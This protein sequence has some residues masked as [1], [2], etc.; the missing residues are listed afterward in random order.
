MNKITSRKLTPEERVR[1]GRLQ[2]NV[3]NALRNT[4]DLSGEIYNLRKEA[5]SLKLQTFDAQNKSE[6]AYIDIS[7]VLIIV[8]IPAIIAIPKIGTMTIYSYF[9]IGLCA[10]VI[11]C[12]YL[13]IRHSLARKQEITRLREDDVDNFISDYQKSVLAQHESVKKQVEVI[14]KELGRFEEIVKNES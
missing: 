2:A 3:S 11:T 13:T 6:D 7:K 9:A 4:A 12:A 14:Q 10:G 8:L 5:L 1:L